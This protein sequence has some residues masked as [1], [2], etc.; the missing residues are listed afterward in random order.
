MY[1]KINVWISL[2]IVISVIVDADEL[3]MDFWRNLM[4]DF[5]VNNW[6]NAPKLSTNGTR[7]YVKI[8]IKTY[9]WIRELRAIKSSLLQ[10]YEVLW[11]QN[12]KTICIVL[13]FNKVLQSDYE[14]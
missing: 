11:T 13:P 14:C 8:S 9:F 4:T 7:A 5:G 3:K 6:P 2:R 10:L 1:S 12:I